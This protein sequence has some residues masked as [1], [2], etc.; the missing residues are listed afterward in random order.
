LKTIRIMSLNAWCGRFMH[1][2]MRFLR[3]PKS[4]AHIYCFQEIVDS[5]H[6]EQFQRHPHEY[7]YGE[8][9]DRLEQHFMPIHTSSFARWEDDMHRMSQSMHIHK[10]LDVRE[11]YDEVVYQATIP[12]ETGSVMLTSRKLQYAFVP[13]SGKRSLMVANMHGAWFPD[14]KMDTPERIAQSRA[15]R[16][17][18]DRHRGPNILCGDFNLRP[19]TESLAILEAGMINLVKQYHV[20]TTRTPLCRFWQQPGWDPY[21][22]YILISPELAIK[23]FQVLPDLASDHAPLVVDVIIEGGEP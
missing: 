16:A 4:A 2:F 17:I 20:P 21:A 9:F 13:L 12:R 23:N 15:I 1:Q 3:G 22:D 19:D 10:Q 5:T 8:M 7:V 11:V 14:N 6:E 18:M